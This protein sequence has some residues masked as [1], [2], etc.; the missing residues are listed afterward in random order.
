MSIGSFNGY[1]GMVNNIKDNIIKQNGTTPKL[2][3]CGGHSEKVID[4]LNE[5][6]SD[7]LEYGS[8]FH[9]KA[10]AYSEDPGTAPIG[11]LITM[12]KKDKL[13]KEFKE[14][15]FSLKE[16]EISAPFETEYGSQVS[17]DKP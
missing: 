16:G 4:K 14:T 3:I 15:A 2:I 1:V 8:S 5:I 13:V 9:N 12:T 7:I 17:T 6:K 11:G 10:I